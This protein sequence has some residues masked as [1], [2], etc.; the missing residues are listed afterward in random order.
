M[1]PLPQR[2][3]VY[4][5]GVGVCP[6]AAAMMLLASENTMAALEPVALG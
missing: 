2:V 3:L 4:P 6:A 5:A 1:M